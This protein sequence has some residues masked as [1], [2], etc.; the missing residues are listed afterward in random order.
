M[1]TVVCVVVGEGRPFAVGI[2]A[3]QIVGILKD[4][5]REKKMYQF[6]SDKL[7][8]YR[9]DGL[10]QISSTQFDFNGTVI[11][12]LSAKTLNHF[13]ST[14]KMAKTSPLSMYPQLDDLSIGK[15]H[16]LVVVPEG[17]ASTLSP[18][19]LW[20]VNGSVENALGVRG[21]RSRL[22]LLADFNHG[23]Y[24]PNHADA[25]VYDGMKLMVHMLFK[26]EE[27]AMDFDTAF[28]FESQTILSPLENL[29]ILSNV[30]QVSC[31][32][33][34]FNLRRVKFGDYDSSD[35]DS[36]E[37]TV[38]D[39][40]YADQSTEEFRFQRIE[41]ESSFGF[42]GR[43]ARVR[44]MS[45]QHCEKYPGCERFKED[46]NNILALSHTIHGPNQASMG[47]TR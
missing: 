17:E 40:S 22:C 46:K 24:D 19:V 13:D 23:F 5:I 43:A 41:K 2:E 10:V 39:I 36:S 27:K 7:D 12:D 35:S 21:V 28:R 18:D 15:I 16:V 33:N 32:S 9:V 45:W 26:T 6:A 1:L 8:L 47:G 42:L 11:D 37:E 30:D 25:F 34:R 31:P 4:K 3:S 44:L 29:T 14:T 20:V 38:S